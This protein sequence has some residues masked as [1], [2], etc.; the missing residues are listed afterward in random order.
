MRCIG[1]WHAHWSGGCVSKDSTGTRLARLAGFPFFLMETLMNPRLHP[2]TRAASLL[3]LS[4]CLSSTAMAQTVAVES[5][6]ASVEAF[7]ELDA[8]SAAY[9]LRLLLAAKGSGAYLADV[10][11]T[12]RSVP[13]NEVVLEHLAEGPLML[14]ALPPGR[15]ELEAR[16]TDVLPGAASVLRRSF[17]IAENGRRELVMYFDTGDRV[18]GQSTAMTRGRP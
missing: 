11:V 15:Y 14:A 1:N 9:S 5:G 12:I 16:Y 4:L 10:N 7:D 13:G 6:G 2:I 18:A 17:T 3:A 8:R